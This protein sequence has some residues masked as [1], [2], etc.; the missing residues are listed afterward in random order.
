MKNIAIIGRTGWLLKSA[1]ILCENGYNIGAV[2]T[3]PAAPEYDVTEV[4]FERF[5]REQNANYLLTTSINSDET[6][7]WIRNQEKMDIAVSINFTGVIGVDVIGSFS[8]GILNGHGGDLPRYRGNACQAWAI[9]NGEERVA[10]CI[11]RMI[12]GELDSGDIVARDY[13]SLAPTTRIGQI[14]DWMRAVTPKLILEA[15]SSLSVNPNWVIEKQSLDPQDSLRCFPRVPDDGKIDW[16]RSGVDVLRL[17]NASSEPYAGAYCYL[18]E[19]LVRFWRALPAPIRPPYVAVN[20]QVLEVN[21]EEGWVEIACGGGTSIRVI[22]ME[23]DYRAKA[24]YFVRS[25]RSRFR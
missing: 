9:L 12:P 18:G 17:I 11:H 20:G 3:A 25:I 10:M 15:L 24:S 6:L 2:I 7:K 4:E 23:W 22:E 14:H 19:N 21:K 1:E 16:S 13:F 8:H 5:A